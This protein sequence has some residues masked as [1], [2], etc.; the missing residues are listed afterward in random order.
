MKRVC[1][2]VLKNNPIYLITWNL[3]SKAGTDESLDSGVPIPTFCPQCCKQK[4][5][6]I[7][8]GSKWT[9]VPNSDRQLP[10]SHH[11]SLPKPR[12]WHFCHLHFEAVWRHQTQLFNEVL[13]VFLWSTTFLLISHPFPELGGKEKTYKNS[14]LDE[15]MRCGGGGAVPQRSVGS[16]H[17]S[18]TRVGIQSCRH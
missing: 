5:V 8:A 9:K 16:T 4:R 12:I 1:Q 10:S 2:L 6:S 17:L 18:T 11:H 3:G 7:T 13:S 15:C 14:C